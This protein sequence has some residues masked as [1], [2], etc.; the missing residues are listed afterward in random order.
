VNHALLGT[1]Y[2]RPRRR[3]LGPGAKGRTSMAKG[4]RNG[5]RKPRLAEEIIV[6][7]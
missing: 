7:A 4:E 6:D 3:T 5:E 1:A 2:R